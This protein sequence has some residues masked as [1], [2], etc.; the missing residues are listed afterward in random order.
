VP[1]VIYDQM[2][3]SYLDDTAVDTAVSPINQSMDMRYKPLAQ[4]SS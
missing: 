2:N 4:K 1:G 3:I